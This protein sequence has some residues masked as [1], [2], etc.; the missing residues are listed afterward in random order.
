MSSCTSDG[1]VGSFFGALATLTLDGAW[2]LEL[3]RTGRIDCIVISGGLV[4]SDL[5]NCV[6]PAQI[7]QA[8][9][10]TRE[11]DQVVIPWSRRRL[12]TVIM[13]GGRAGTQST[14]ETITSELLVTLR[15][16]VLTESLINGN[17]TLV[18]SIDGTPTNEIVPFTLSRR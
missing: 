11:G 6:D 5:E 16:V 18:G 3:D 15:G 4:T 2:E 12:T 9:D 14:V 8:F 17:A 10:I 1:P 7:L 13:P